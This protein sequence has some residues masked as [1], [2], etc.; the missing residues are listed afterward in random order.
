MLT[1]TDLLLLDYIADLPCKVPLLVSH[2]AA[3]L[4]NK[5]SLRL[6]TGDLI[7]KVNF[8]ESKGYISKKITQQEHVLHLTAL[9]AAIWESFFKP[10][11]S[12]YILMESFYKD[13][14]EFYEISALNSD[15]LNSIAST[16]LEKWH[17]TGTLKSITPW[18]ATYWKNFDSGY[19]F[20]FK[21]Q[22][23]IDQELIILRDK[24]RL[25]WSD[26]Y[27]L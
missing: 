22:N 20:R 24:W 26:I 13:S 11:W 23:D 3:D 7:K 1:N 14:Y 19:V 12:K 10:E 2:D 4:F 5:P 27:L 18:E 6:G 15:K 21:T 16:L 25:N 9:G 17:I 8:L